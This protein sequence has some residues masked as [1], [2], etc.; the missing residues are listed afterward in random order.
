M[1]KYFIF[2]LFLLTSCTIELENTTKF[3]STEPV[4]NDFKV[5]EKQHVKDVVCNYRI[6]SADST[7]TILLKDACSKWEVQQQ[8]I[9][10]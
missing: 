3:K 10:K 9:I 6:M 4:V 1:A 2:T 7:Q 8:V 5:T